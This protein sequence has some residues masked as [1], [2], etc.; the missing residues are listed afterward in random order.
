MPNVHKNNKTIRINLKSTKNQISH[1]I[2]ILKKI[3]TYQI[4]IN[5][6]II[7]QENHFQVTQSIQEI[8]HHI[9]PVI[10]VDR[11]NEEIHEISHKIDIADRIAKITKI[12]IPN[13][14]QTQHN[15]FLHPVPIQIQGIDTIPIID[16]ETHHTTEIETIHTLEIEVILT[17]EIRTIQ[18]TDQDLIHIID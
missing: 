1:S 9:T 4:K 17:I 5:I 8:N 18:T 12:T 16:H 7:V 15:L 13:R 2:N 11:P 14:I 10:E 6:V 3:K